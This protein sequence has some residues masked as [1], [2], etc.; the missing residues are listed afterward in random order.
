MH[1]KFLFLFLCFLLVSFIGNSQKKD[2]VVPVTDEWEE[3]GTL[4]DNQDVTVDIEFKLSKKQCDSTGFGASNHLFRY[5]IYAKRPPKGEDLFLTF[6]IIY[7]DC[8]GRYI[9]K[10]NN[11]NIG[12]KRK[13]DVWDGLQPLIDLNDDNFFRGSRLIVPFSDVRILKSKDPTKDSEC[14]KKIVSIPTGLTSKK[15]P[16]KPEAAVKVEEPAF[17][18]T[19]NAEAELAAKS[20]KVKSTTI[21]KNRKSDLRI[22]GPSGQIVRGQKFRIELSDLTDSEWNWYMDDCNGQLIK[23]ASSF[24]EGI[25]DESTTF[26]AKPIVNNS[27]KEICLNYHVM[28]DTVSELSYPAQNLIM[29]KNGKVCAG[30]LV[31]MYP[32]GGLLGT[33]AK[34][35]WF[36]DTCGGEPYYEGDTLFID[37]PKENMTFYVR[38][39]GKFNTTECISRQVSII[40]PNTDLRKIVSDDTINCPGSLVKLSISGSPMENEP[41]W[42]WT[43]NQNENLGEGLSISYRPYITTAIYAQLDGLCEAPIILSKDLSVTS[44]SRA[45]ENARV[46]FIDDKNIKIKL[47]GGELKGNSQ[48]TWYKNNLERS[49]KILSG[50]STFQTVFDPKLSYLIRAEGACDTTLAIVVDSIRLKTSFTYLSLGI[51]PVDVSGT[52][53]SKTLLLSVGRI[54]NKFGWFV[55]AKYAPPS[56]VN[57]SLNTNN[58]DLV[59]YSSSNTYYKFNGELKTDRMALIGGLHLGLTK[60][61]FFNIGAGYG[62]RSLFW[63]INEFSMSNSGSQVGKNFAKNVI[64]S[65]SGIEIETGITLIAGKFNFTTGIGYLGL[66]SSSKSF[67]DVSISIGINL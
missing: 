51:S 58:S 37:A 21:A 29:S 48:W 17:R 28:V 35:Q 39:F 66:G 7:Q 2:V 26:Y 49:N 24:Y 45:P 5:K 60:Q 40:S 25:A 19:E 53:T 43:N 20:Q 8:Y 15:T 56:G 65:T 64:H 16:P 44:L 38:A 50:S 23:S 1:K 63:G 34:W 42:K 31:K 47:E 52:Q 3:G 12:V 33:A 41:T 4:L 27:N 22:K 30:E 9:C 57:T 10:T 46:S 55:K 61:L 18:S 13:N 62:S 6:K 59:N 54:S 14:Y 67:T 11:L 32:M 36:K